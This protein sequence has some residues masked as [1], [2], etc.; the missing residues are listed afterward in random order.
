MNDD[1]Y[2]TLAEKGLI[3]TQEADLLANVP[4]GL[5]LTPFCTCG[6]FDP[7]RHFLSCDLMYME[8][9]S[10]PRKQL[11]QGKYYPLVPSTERR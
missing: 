1:E 5:S 3:S 10:F 6:S 9:K 8:G 2:R 11:Q 4:E 7:E